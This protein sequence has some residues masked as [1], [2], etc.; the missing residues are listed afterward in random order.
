MNITRDI[1]IFSKL[2]LFQSC[3][4]G[5]LNICSITYSIDLGLGT[6]GSIYVLGLPDPRSLCGCGPV[7]KK[8]TYTY[9]HN[10]FKN[11]SSHRSNSQRKCIISAWFGI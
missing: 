3:L 5:L 8:E 10:S 7:K 4:G 6:T 1:S 2:K 11:V 9:M